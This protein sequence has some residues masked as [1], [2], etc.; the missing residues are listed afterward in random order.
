MSQNTSQAV[1]SRRIEAPDSLDFY[2]TPPWATRAL[3]EYLI[4][5]RGADVIEPACGDGAMARPLSEYARSVAAFDVHD[6]GVGYPL[7]DFLM[8]FLPD[9]CGNCTWAIT[10]P[11]FRLA[12]QFIHRALEVVEIGVAMLVRSVFAESVGRYERL[13][14][15]RPPAIVAQFVERV[16]M[17][18]GRLSPDGSTAT[19]YAWMVWFVGSTHA[20]RFMWVPPCRKR[21]E[22]ASDYPADCHD[23]FPKRGD[24]TPTPP[25][26]S[27]P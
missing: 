20:P 6:Y 22:R 27:R 16:V 9:G 10:N 26:P 2:P 13:F 3:C 21:L 25:A 7:H 11:P 17:H 1:M 12:E 14:R 15:D 23:P 4:D 8:P 19:S 24:A 18:K 5:I